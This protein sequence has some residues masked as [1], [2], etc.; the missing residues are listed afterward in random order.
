MIFR[1]LE[2]II[3]VFNAEANFVVYH[4]RHGPAPAFYWSSSKTVMRQY[5]G[6]S[7]LIIHPLL[8]SSDLCGEK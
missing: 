6:I 3:D 4:K 8:T 5:F 1:F 2:S 7:M